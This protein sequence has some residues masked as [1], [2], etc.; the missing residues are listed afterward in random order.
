M[1][2]T[3]LMAGPIGRLY[4]GDSLA[5]GLA[6]ARE[7][8]LAVYSH[9]DLNSIEVPCLPVVN[10]PLWE[11]SH[12]AWFQEYWCLRGGDDNEPSLLEGSDALFNSS[13]VPSTFS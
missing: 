10:P 6:D 9:L 2:T 4:E 11:L 5:A 13:E 7:R 1:H 12:I 3:G 8:S